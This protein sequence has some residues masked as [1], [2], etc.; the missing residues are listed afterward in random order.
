VDA[1]VGLGRIHGIEIRLHLS[2]FALALL[3][4]LSLSAHFESAHPDWGRGV[5]VLSSVITSVL[6]FVTLVLH[7]LSHAAVARRNALPVESI[8]LFA[9]G[10][11]ARIRRD[12]AD[13]RTEF[14]MAIAGPLVSALIGAL[15]LG[16]ALTLGWSPAAEPNS[17]VLATLVWL[18][19]I[20]LSLAVFNMIPGFP[21]DGGRVLRA[22]LWW[23][24]KDADRST[25]A[26]AMVGQI[27][28][29]LL[30]FTGLF[31]FFGDEGLPG[32]WMALIGW[33]LLSAAG[34]S[35]RQSQTWQRLRG[36][37]VC[38]V[39][40]RDCAFVDGRTSVQEFVERHLQHPGPHCYVVLERGRPAGLVTPQDLRALRRERW[41]FVTLDAVMQPLDRLKAVSAE[42]SLRESLEAMVEEDVSQLPVIDDGHLEGVVSRGSILGFLK[43]RAELRF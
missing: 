3:L 24:T 9:L 34:A 41:P 10:G 35:L 6:F 22:A 26:A 16:L 32:L 42:T 4:V 36:V 17:P 5:V 14:W 20:N 28:G 1:N 21:L 38:D 25:W 18:G 12:A 40:A 8:T 29:G 27:V 33:F 13:A 2:W 37:R 30:I 23:M 15:T 19:Y 7:E 39:M 31:R 43:T 11:V